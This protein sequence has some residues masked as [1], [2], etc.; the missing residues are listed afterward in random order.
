MSK[1]HQ[2]RI[3]VTT[4]KK[5]Y[6]PGD[7]VPVGGKDG[8]GADDIAAIEAIHGIW[9]GGEAP[10]TAASD[11]GVVLKAAEKAREDAEGRVAALTAVIDAQQAVDAASA[12]LSEKPEDIDVL[13]SLEAAE[14]A[15]ADAKAAAG[16]AGGK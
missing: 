2:F 13:A 8:V 1:T 14:K 10:A 15:L 7:P 5:S 9:D 16:L 4:G 3:T 11:D 12:A 6:A